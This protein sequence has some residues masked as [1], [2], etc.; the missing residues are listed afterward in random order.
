MPGRTAEEKVKGVSTK[1]FA[2]TT[3]EMMREQVKARE[4]AL[5]KAIN[6]IEGAATPQQIQDRVSQETKLAKEYLKDE[7]DRALK[8]KADVSSKVDPLNAA[9]DAT[10]EMLKKKPIPKQ[11]VSER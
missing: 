6:D 9:L 8:V 4:G 5:S 1:A 11:P 3:L 2:V 7:K 10:L